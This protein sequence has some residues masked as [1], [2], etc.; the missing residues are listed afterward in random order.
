M[1]FVALPEALHRLGMSEI[2][3]KALVREEGIQVY[4][5]D[6][7]GQQVICFKED[8][9]KTLEKVHSASAVS[10]L[11]EDQQG[12]DLIVEDDSID[13]DVSEVLAPSP[14]ESL[15]LDL[16]A[17]IEIVSEAEEDTPQA[18]FELGDEDIGGESFEPN[19]SP[20]ESLDLELGGED[21]GLVVSPDE[22]L[23]LDLG[24]DDELVDSPDESL[25]LDMDG[26]E[27]VDEF[28]SSPSESSLEETLVMDSGDSFDSEGAYGSQD[29]TLSIEGND[30]L[31]FDEDGEALSFDRP[32]NISL[33]DD[34]FSI[35]EEDASEALGLAQDQDVPDVSR[36]T[37]EIVDEDEVG[38]VF[39]LM[40][41]LTFGFIVFNGMILFGM[42]QEL[43]NGPGVAV[44]KNIFVSVK[45]FVNSKFPPPSE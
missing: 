30:T 34:S 3:L 16:G 37:T 39:P 20:D 21:T 32:D 22:S 26:S 24:G 18:S 36:P 40:S 11:N 41:V 1:A 12:S 31:S 15:D 7:D 9:F 45:D 42:T 35:E 23:D 5:T 25:D 38:I 8:E 6:R 44:G 29:A 10:V 43:G 13:L 14:D 28:S 2:D 4:R 17:S 27:P 33:P 19:V